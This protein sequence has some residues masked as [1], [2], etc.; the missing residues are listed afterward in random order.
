M[1]RF[2]SAAWRPGPLKPW[3]LDLS[4]ASRP[5]NQVSLTTW[6]Q[7]AERP[8]ERRPQ[9]SHEPSRRFPR[10]DLVSLIQGT[11]FPRI[12]SSW[13]SS[14]A[15]GLESLASRFQGKSEPI[16]QCSPEPR[17]TETSISRNQAGSKTRRLETLKPSCLGRPR[18]HGFQAER[19]GRGVRADRSALAVLAIKGKSRE[20]R[21][22]VRRR[23]RSSRRKSGSTSLA[24]R[25]RRG[26]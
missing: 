2:L 6:R 13:E 8:I 23:K 16:R 15:V 11:K 7:V 20:S 17:Q 1:D 25:V 18:S 14:S 26:R 24:G 9:G 4:R 22:R 21:D 10:C 3:N 12:P 19:W 5:T